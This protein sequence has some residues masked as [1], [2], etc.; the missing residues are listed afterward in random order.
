M[1]S[2]LFRRPRGSD[3]RGL[4]PQTSPW[5]HLLA[6]DWLGRGTWYN[7]G[8][9]RVRSPPGILG[10][11]SF[12]RDTPEVTHSSTGCC[13]TETPADRRGSWL[14]AVTVSWGGQNAPRCCLGPELERL[15]HRLSWEGRLGDLHCCEDHVHHAASLLTTKSTLKTPAQGPLLRRPPF[16]YVRF[17][18]AVPLS[19]PSPS[20]LFHFHLLCAPLCTHHTDTPLLAFLRP[21]TVV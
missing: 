2:F 21:C 9:C 19:C 18:L 14:G 1:A 11:G 5:N 17:K 3:H 10:K 20:P 13:L 8:Q 7:P 16:R 15:L 12:T 6:S 4:T